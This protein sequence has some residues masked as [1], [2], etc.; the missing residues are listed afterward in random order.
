MTALTKR[1]VI[2]QST[3]RKGWMCALGDL[4][5]KGNQGAANSSCVPGIPKDFF[6]SLHMA[7]SLFLEDHDGLPPGPSL[8]RTTSS[9]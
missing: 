2:T 9:F 8:L 6:V 1:G 4:Q 5:Q 3:I 7:P